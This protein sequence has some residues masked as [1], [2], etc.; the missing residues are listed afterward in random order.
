MEKGGG[1]FCALVDT[2]TETAKSCVEYLF[3]K[4]I[5]EINN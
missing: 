4:E 1:V 3:N 5:Y 2:L